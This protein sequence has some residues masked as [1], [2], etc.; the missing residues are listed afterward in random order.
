MKEPGDLGKQAGA[1]CGDAQAPPAEPSPP[2][3]PCSSAPDSEGCSEELRL[4]SPALLRAAHSTHTVT[5]S[6]HT[7]QQA[8]KRLVRKRSAQALPGPACC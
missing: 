4:L 8:P 3:H 5:V 6:P 7:S 1:R 2:Q